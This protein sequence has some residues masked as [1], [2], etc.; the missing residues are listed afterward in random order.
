MIVE[1]DYQVKLGANLGWDSR[2]HRVECGDLVACFLVESQRFVVVYDT[3]LGPKSGQWLRQQALNLASGRPLLVVNSHAD[4]DHYF[5]NMA[6]P[7]PIVG[8]RECA[9]RVKEV[10]GPA[11]L[12]KKIQD[13]PTSY[14]PVELVP[15]SI[16]VT[17]PTVLDGG[18]LTFEL[19]PTPGH[20]PDHLALW[21][22]EL[23][24]LF[25]GDCL[26]DPIPLVDED[27]QAGDTTV[28][29][30]LKSIQLMAAK[31]PEWVL[32]NHAPPDRGDQLLNRNSAYLDEGLRL[33]QACSSLEEL[34]QRFPGPETLEGFYA[35]AHQRNLTYCFQQASRV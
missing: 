34:A 1:E 6:F 11:E 32:A 23:S 30:L 3:L 7:E 2:I 33:A 16:L 10:A 21:I 13:C 14:R 28:S 20:R 26:E 17:G 24:I 29:Q 5:G 27:S 15:P 35:E 4:W 9:R 18:D 22:R 25:P 12:A 19:L 31:K 8:S